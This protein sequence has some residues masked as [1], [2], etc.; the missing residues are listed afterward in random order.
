MNRQGFG[1]AQDLQPVAMNPSPP[2]AQRAVK[3][4]TSEGWDREKERAH[5]AFKRQ[6]ESIAAANADGKR[7][8]GVVREFLFEPKVRLSAALRSLGGQPNHAQAFDLRNS[9]NLWS[10]QQQPIVWY[11]K[12]KRSG[13]FRPICI[14]PPALKAAHYMIAAA[15][16]AQLPPTDTL[17]GIR[18]RG[19]ADA[20]LELK[21]LQNAGFVYFG[22]SDIVNCF[23]NIDPN[24]LYRLPLPQ[25][26]IRHTLDHRN[27][28]FTGGTGQFASQAVTGYSP[29]LRYQLHK[30][31][32]PTGLLQG[33]P[34][35]SAI[36]AWLLKDIPTSMDAR[37]VLC[38]DNIMVAARTAAGCKGMME[39]LTAYFR[40]CP[41]GPL[42]MCEVEYAD[43]QPIEFLGALLDPDRTDIGIAHGTL[44]RIEKRLGEAEEADQ[45]ECNRIWEEH[46]RRATGNTISATVNPF[47][48]N[49]PTAIWH[50]LRDVRAGMPY[51]DVECPELALLLE[52]SA[53]AA[54]RQGRDMASNLHRNLFAPAW[55]EQ[56]STIKNIL[57][58]HPRP[59]RNE[60]KCSV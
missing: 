32:G 11:P 35:S 21:R 8:N 29:I 58:R 6:T 60:P 57:Q 56:A 49:C 46:Q 22:K 5:R 7:V 26:V 3:S 54:D 25:E 9:V 31:S 42:A 53:T 47:L 24:A 55:T 51:L 14:L 39:T 33:S 19:V 12:A 44:S 43:N 34:A 17:Y 23:Q 59:K 45:L 10:D 40:H 2:A 41:A 37:V 27:L 1:Q 18:G 4:W 15:I 48:S 13:G 20:V 38:F 50:I 16:S 28:K 30:A 52:V 36:L